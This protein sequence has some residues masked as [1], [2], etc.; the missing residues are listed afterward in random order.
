MKTKLVVAFLALSALA[1]CDV[2]PQALFGKDKSED[3]ATSTNPIETG[4]G[5][6]GDGGV[7]ALP[8]RDPFEGAPAFAV[9]TPS[10]VTTDHHLGD[11]NAGTDCLACHG[12]NMGA[13]AFVLAGTIPGA[14]NAEVRVVDADGRE[15]ASVGTDANGNFWF[16]G[17]D[18]FPAGSSVGVRDATTT[19]KM[20]GR[21]SAGS[22]NTSSCHTRAR[23]IFLAK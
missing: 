3:P 2:L 11:S 23:P 4:D 12:K 19:Q 5:A 1:G 21:I 13:P 22:C 20:S 15:V 7:A 17:T 8:A 14:T 10:T 18:A 6:N 9:K 16:P